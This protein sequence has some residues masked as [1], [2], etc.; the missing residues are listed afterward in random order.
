MKKQETIISMLAVTLITL[1]IVIAGSTAET[2]KAS[3]QTT[4]DFAKTSVKI[5]NLKKDR[6][7]SGSILRSSSGGSDILTNEHVCSLLDKGGVILR[8]SEEFLV[9]AYKTYEIHDLCLVRVKEN[10]EVNL[11][12]APSTPVKFQ[13][14]ITSGHPAL[15]PHVLSR[16]DFSGIELVDVLV[17]IQ[18]CKGNEP[19]EDMLNCLF[20][21]GLPIVRSYEAQLVS[22]T[23]LPGSSGS[24]VF[25]ALGEISGVV[26]ASRSRELSYALIVPHSYVKD[27]INI[28]STI[29]Y[30]YPN[31]KRVVSTSKVE[32][33]IKGC[34]KMIIKNRLCDKYAT[35]MLWEK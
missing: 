13:S 34:N 26:F 31:N 20:M 17:G 23:I 22:A 33:N 12:V 8:E 11:N 3:P 25:N 15:L 10:L 9:V 2:P 16:G 18:P 14:A 6:G 27:F 1:G 24:A 5:L 7:G 29:A 28:E 21:G 4:S 19:V 32:S 30:K 35:T